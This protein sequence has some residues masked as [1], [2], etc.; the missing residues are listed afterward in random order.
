MLSC[1][2][3]SQG[4]EKYQ[5]SSQNNS[6]VNFVRFKEHYG[7]LNKLAL[8]PNPDKKDS[9]GLLCSMG[10]RFFLL[11]LCSVKNENIKWDKG[12]GH[13]DKA[14]FKGGIKPQVLHMCTYAS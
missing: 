9:I 11:C 6:S 1:K 12:W 14:W 7:Y 13:V 3:I 8:L 5:R 10:K 2:Q 4:S